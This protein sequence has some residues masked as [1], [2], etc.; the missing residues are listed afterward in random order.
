[1]GVIRKLASQTAIYGLSSII[2][3]IAVWGLT[4]LF[5]AKMERGEYGVFNDLYSFVTYFL[6]IL[7]FGMETAFFRFSDGDKANQKPYAQALIFV[8]GLGVLFLLAGSLG[9]TSFGRLLGYADRPNLVLMVLWITFFDVVTSLPM[10]KLRYDERP[11]VFATLSLFNIF[12]TIAL[13]LFFIL[14]LRQ[15]SAEYVFLANLI[16]SAIKFVMLV[17]VSLPVMKMLEGKGRVASKFAGIELLPGKWEVDRE[18]MRSM[19]GFGLYIMLAG[20]FGMI[21]QNSDVNFITRLWPDTPTPYRGDMLDAK[22]MAGVFSAN[23]K[24]AVFILLVTQAFRY[25]AEPFFFRHARQTNSRVVFA[26][27]FHYFMLASLAT[28][29]LIS[30]FAYEFVSIRILG[31]Q[32]VDQKYWNGL[33]VVAPLLFGAVIWGAYTNLTIWYKLTKQVR[34]GILFSGIG[35]VSIVLLFWLM[36]PPWG[37]MGAAYAIILCYLLLAAMVYFAGQ[38]YYFIPYKMGRMLVHTCIYVGAYAIAARFGRSEILSGLFFQKLFIC[39][40][41]LGLSYALERFWPVAW[42]EPKKVE[43]A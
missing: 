25:A 3:R 28:F 32:L 2:G 33:A 6:V 29:L 8:T 17:L 38:K 24:L 27:V 26:R 4:P 18:L 40:A 31:F 21:N 7:T 35:V 20:L 34:F 43:G 30:T 12:V 36:I 1:M 9:T 39:L 13:N 10:A 11:I 23:K 41:A 22:S 16:A 19:A 37:Y 5:T 14:G 42:V 15:T